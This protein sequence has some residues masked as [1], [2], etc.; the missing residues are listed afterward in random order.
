MYSRGDLVEVCSKE[1]GFVGS[2]YEASIVSQLRKDLFVVMYKNLVEGVVNTQPL[3]ET[4]RLDELRPVPPPAPENDE[5]EYG[6]LDLVDAW[7]NDGW[8]VGRISGRKENGDYFVYFEICGDEIAYPVSRLR[9][10]L[11]WVKKKWVSSDN[12]KGRKQKRRRLNTSENN[13]NINC[14]SVN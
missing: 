12:K 7:D 13:N 6:Y 11:D 2:Y 8:W 4:V 5:K 10:H 14:S 3:V 1:S 9:V